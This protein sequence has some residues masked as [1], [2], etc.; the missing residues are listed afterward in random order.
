MRLSG[1]M[2]ITYDKG[3]DAIRFLTTFKRTDRWIYPEYIFAPS[4]S[5]KNAA[6]VIFEIKANKKDISHG[7]FFSSLMAVLDSGKDRWLMF[8]W[9]TD[10]WETR[11]IQFESFNPEQLKKLR[12]GMNPNCNDFTY[13]IRNLKIYYDLPEK[14]IKTKQVKK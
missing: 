1:K 3:E 8:S 11:I 2:E 10:Q 4:E 9:A 12:I 14:Q 13:F 7:L 6:G 5:L